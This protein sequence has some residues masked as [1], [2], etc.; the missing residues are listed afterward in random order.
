MLLRPAE[1]RKP[2]NQAE[3]GRKRAGNTKWRKASR[4]NRAAGQKEAGHAWKTWNPKSFKSN[5]LQPYNPSTL[6]AVDP[7]IRYL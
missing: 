4:K 2:Q 6:Q 1:W 5:I 7:D 3:E